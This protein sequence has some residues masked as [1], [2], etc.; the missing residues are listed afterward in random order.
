MICMKNLRFSSCPRAKVRRQRPPG[1]ARAQP[2]L[3]AAIL[4]HTIQACA[5]D[6][7]FQH[8]MRMI[9]LSAFKSA[10]VWDACVGHSKWLMAFSG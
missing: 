10:S 3:D 6:I 1:S 4:K 5:V 9:L 2:W 8:I 7:S